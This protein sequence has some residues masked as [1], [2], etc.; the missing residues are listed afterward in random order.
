MARCENCGLRIEDPATLCPSCLHHKKKEAAR[1]AR[2][3]TGRDGAVEAPPKPVAAPDID[4]LRERM[5]RI[6]EGL[7]G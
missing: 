4:D 5:R 2:E 6:K 1:A 3:G 7:G